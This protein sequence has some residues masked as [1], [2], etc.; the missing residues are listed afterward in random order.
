MSGSNKRRIIKYATLRMLF[1]S[2][3]PAKRKQIAGY[4]KST[5]TSTIE[6]SDTYRAII[7]PDNQRDALQSAPGTMM[8]D[9]V[10]KLRQVYEN[11]LPGDIEIT[12][13]NIIS[14]VKE[15]KEILGY[16][17]PDRVEVTQRGLFLHMAG[18][19][20][21]QLEAAHKQ[22]TNPAKVA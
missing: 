18:Y 2:L 22:L 10:N 9:L 17:P 13:G 19:S 7:S 4:S 21:E 1:P 3:P 5:D 16:Q 11:D 14:A 8:I 15:T 20:T 6:Q 12:A